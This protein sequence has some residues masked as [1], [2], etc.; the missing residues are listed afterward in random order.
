MLAVLINVRGRVQGVGF[1]WWA[2]GEARYRNLSGYAQNLPDGSVELRFQGEPEAVGRMVR[3]VT[4]N[5]STSSRPGEV[6]DYDLSRVEV[7]PGA[8]AF[9]AR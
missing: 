3:L 9:S 7:V 6:V 2:T 5:P 1:R 8:R 4:E